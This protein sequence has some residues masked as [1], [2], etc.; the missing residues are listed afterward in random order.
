MVGAPSSC[1]AAEGTMQAATIT[2]M[3]ADI[4]IVNGRVFRGFAH[5][6]P[7]P[8]GSDI[9]ARPPGAPTA[10]AISGGR[11]AWVGADADAMRDWRES[12]TEV[13]DA[14]GGLVV[15]GFEDA[16][17]HVLSGGR[18]LDRVNL[19][20]LGTV[21]AI[22]DRIRTYATDHP[23]AD[24]ILGRGWLYAPFPG[25]LP[26]R[27]QLDA[28]LPDRPA[29][30]GCYDG[31][32]A[33]V[34]TTALAM[35]GIDRS[36]PDPANGLIER[37]GA[38][39]EPTGVLKEAA[40][41]LV[42][43]IVPAPGHEQDGAS[44]RRAVRALNAAGV[45]A[46]QDAWTTQDELSVW[47]AVR[48]RG[49]LTV[50]AR[51]ALPMEPGQT[52]GEWR[53][54]LDGYA[55]A[56]ADLEGDR[57]LGSGILKAM[58]DGVIESRTAAMLTPYEG[59][60]SSGHP[61]FGVDQ[62]DAFV[63]EADRRGWQIEIHAI[64]DRGVRMTLDAFE[65]AAAANGPWIGS[66][67][68][69]E[70]RGAALHG[71]VARPL[72]ERRHR[73]E[74]IETIAAEDVG[75]FGR[76]GVVASMQPYHGVPTPNQID[77]WSA[78][79]GPERASRAWAYRSLHDHGAVLALGSDWPVVPFDPMLEL[80]VATTRLDDDGNPAGGWLPQERLPLPVALAA[81][82]WGSAYASGSEDRRG[83]IEPGLDADVAVLDRDLLAE[84]PGVIHGTAVTTT[85][86]G[87]RIVHREAR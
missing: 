58:A 31:H 82:G 6:S 33:W 45:T 57:W 9:G 2:A 84:G 47:R 32:T 1:H 48:D 23:E 16:H 81:Y 24:W 65:R 83:R 76:L 59:D 51:L 62:L 22:L 74:H 60:T 64:G 53:D 73:V 49:E 36:T 72:V 7:I 50:R 34:N 10:V 21:E 30:L 55:A 17:I 61:E 71:A 5:G 8:L 78:A 63:A 3:A 14:R 42:R 13:V 41:E 27:T 80:H 39:G 19:Y 77:V 35:A 20:P 44:L 26:T 18:S 54:R 12:T 37:D 29:F 66:P 46:V 68:A 43:A 69:G 87:G 86:V 75:R 56:I 11:I 67:A 52:L 40:M 28:V 4:L 38:T 15:P 79:I 25:G 85:L 70:A